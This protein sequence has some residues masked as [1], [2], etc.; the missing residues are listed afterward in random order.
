MMKNPF[1]GPWPC[2]YQ[3][4][5][6]ISRALAQGQP[7]T[8]DVAGRPQDGWPAPFR[9]TGE[10]RAR[11]TRM[12]DVFVIGVTAAPPFLSVQRPRRKPYP[13]S[14]AGRWRAITKCALCGAATWEFLKTH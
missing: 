10:P 12:H 6:A 8:Q 7:N 13:P 11:L 9:R 4:R 14:T 2:A 5:I 3:Q 1:G